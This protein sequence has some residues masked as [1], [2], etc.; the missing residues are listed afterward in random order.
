MFETTIEATQ[1]PEDRSKWV[2][3]FYIYPVGLSEK[4]RVDFELICECD[5]ELAGQ[6]V[7][8]QMCRVRLVIAVGNV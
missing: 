6:E 5:C 1:C 7:G 4:L 2:D 8:L 3:Q